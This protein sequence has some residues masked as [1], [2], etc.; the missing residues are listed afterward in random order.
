[1]WNKILIVFLIVMFASPVHALN[2]S[3]VKTWSAEVLTHTDLN[4]EFDNILNH[5]IVNAD[6]GAAAAIVGSKLD[7]S[8]PG[9]IGGTTPGAGA[10]TTLSATGAATIGDAVT[11]TLQ[12]NSNVIYLEGHAVDAHEVTVQTGTLAA[13]S[14]LT[15]P[16]IT[17]TIVTSAG[18]GGD[19]DIGA[20][21]MRAQTLESDQTTGTAPI[22]VASTTVC[23]NL[24]VDQVD[25]LDANSTATAS[26]LYPLNASSVYP[27]SVIES[28]VRIKGWIQFNGTGT[29]AIN[30]SYNVSG[31]TDNGTGDYTVTW[32]TDFANG[33]YCV[34]L[35]VSKASDIN[36]VGVIDDDVTPAVGSVRIHSGHTDGTTFFDALTVCVLA[37][38]DQ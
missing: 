8:V 3:R 18:S 23:A 30:D 31:I 14:T 35:S 22:A 34:L 24:N 7:L 9:A 15:I 27:A 2:L 26:T 37:I 28:D 10:F 36:A 16:N 38:G 1:M 13:D 25:G 5:S 19:V 11:D 33:N 6:I 29:I 21:E 17:G 4:A 12:I 32:D 20:Y